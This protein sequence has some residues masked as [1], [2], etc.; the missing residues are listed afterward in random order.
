MRPH[1][2]IAFL[3]VLGGAVWLSGLVV[4]SHPV[5]AIGAILAALLF[6]AVFAARAQRN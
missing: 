2:L 5:Y 3:L 6:A 1:T 4:G